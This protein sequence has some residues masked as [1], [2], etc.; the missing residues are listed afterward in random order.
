MAIA[1]N[2]SAIA[3]LRRSWGRGLIIAGTLLFILTALAQ[4]LNAAGILKLGLTNWRP[5]L[6]AFLVFAVAIG[7]GQVLMRGQAGWRALFILPAGLFT[8]AMAIFPTLFGLSIAL[9]PLVSVA[10]ALAMASSIWLPPTLLPGAVMPAVA[11]FLFGFGPILWTISQT[12]L[13]QAVTPAAML[14]RVSALV[15][16]ATAGARPIG[17]AI[18]GVVGAG[19]GPESCLVLA[20]LG[21]AVQAGVIMASPVPR[22]VRL[23]PPHWNVDPAAL[24]AAFS[25]RTKAVLLNNP[26]NPAAK[27]FSAGEL[28]TLAELIVEHDAIAICDEVYEHIAFDGRR[29]QPLMTLPGMRERTVR[30]GSAG[31]TLS[32]TGWKVGYVTA[33]PHILEPIAKAH[34]FTTFTTPP[35]LQRAVAFGLG[36]DDG[37]YQSLSGDLEM[38]RDR[39]A[40]GL[41]RIG[42]GV[43][44]CEG[45]YFI[46][47]DVAPLGINEGDY[48][49]LAPLRRAGPPF[50]LSPTELARHRMITSG[51]MTPALDRL[52]RKGFVT[53]RPNPGDRRSSLVVLTDAGLAVVDEAMSVH[54]AVEQRLVAALDES[55]RA[56]LTDTLRRLLIANEPA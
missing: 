5:T 47:G 14:G 20:A 23:E 8:V 46:A 3:P 15:M 21:F 22:L 43:A 19:Y 53:R 6:F 12:T 49:I 18:G 40:A 36:K 27:I 39:F 41:E 34:Q 56:S 17:A 54:A 28:A 35:N 33:P 38:K 50:A 45:T 1:S 13:R 32:L 2:Q 29:H 4:A 7:A 55:E 11:F 44:R 31:K 16:M 26:Q 37:Y 52:E 30:I 48:G 25:P 51:G 9:G 10:A 42:F 24:A